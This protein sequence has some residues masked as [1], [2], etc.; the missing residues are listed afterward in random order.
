MALADSPAAQD[1]LATKT[2]QLCDVLQILLRKEL[3]LEGM[4][5]ETLLR[6]EELNLLYEMGESI[7][8]DMTIDQIMTQMLERAVEITDAQGG[9][10]VLFP[11]EVGGG[12]PTVEAV[13]GWGSDLV[14]KGKAIELQPGPVGQLLTQGRPQVL[15]EVMDEQLYGA[16]GR[17]VCLQS[18]LC[19]PLATTARL[20]GCM[21][22]VN[23]RQDAYFAAG[24][25]KLSLAIAIQAAIAIENSRLQQRIREEERIGAS[26]QRYVSP[27]VVRAVLE[28][29]GL[30]ELIGDR[31]WATIVFVDIRDFAVLV[32]KT[33]PKIV[34]DL[35]DEYLREMTE[36]IFRYQ[37]A[38][39]EFAGDQL[40]AFFGIPLATPKGAENAVRAALDMVHRMGE[41]RAS[42]AQRGLPGFRIG[43]GMSTGWVAVGNIGSEKRMELTVIGP[44]VVIAS[45]VEDLNKELGTRILV[46]QDTFDEV[47]DLVLYRERGTAAL[48]GISRPVPIYE[49]TGIRQADEV[50]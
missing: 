21:I 4:G 7:I 40:L 25:E 49:I 15:G 3:Q 35:L 9:M 14:A 42:W 1:T 23:K 27:N 43:V 19:V 36:I 48:K 50:S 8:S 34:R 12:A 16:P 5:R 24:D 18:L 20:V 41:L 22:L 11:A 39:D 17:P 31:W 37:G 44:P 2:A 10:I 47:R 28:R 33:P 30:Q 6:Y 46:T 13:L 32:E 45:R 26:L 38:I 29:G